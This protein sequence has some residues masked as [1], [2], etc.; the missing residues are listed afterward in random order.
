[1]KFRMTDLA[2]IIGVSLIAGPLV[3]GWPLGVVWYI[4]ALIG[5]VLV[6]IAGYDAQARMLKMGAPGEDLLQKFWAVFKQKIKSIRF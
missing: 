4:G 1:M 2:L 5:V 3:M 6:S